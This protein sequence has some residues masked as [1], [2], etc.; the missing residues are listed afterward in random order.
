MGTLWK[1][2]LGV[3][4]MGHVDGGMERD[5]RV[6]EYLELVP[7]Y[8]ELTTDEDPHQPQQRGRK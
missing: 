7:S 1:H 3:V 4:E 6:D 8:Y 2:S 5:T